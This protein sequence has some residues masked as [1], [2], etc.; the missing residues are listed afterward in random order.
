MANHLKHFMAQSQDYWH[1]AKA[2]DDAFKRLLSFVMPNPYLVMPP[3]PDHVLH[4]SLELEDEEEENEDDDNTPAWTL[5]SFLFLYYLFVD[6]FYFACWFG[7]CFQ[8]LVIFN[9]GN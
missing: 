2:G 7:F 5:G 8:F 3:F 6:R 1:Y 9:V 4:N